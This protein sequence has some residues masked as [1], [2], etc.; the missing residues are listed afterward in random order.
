MSSDIVTNISGI[1]HCYASGPEN[2]QAC[3]RSLI[4]SILGLF[5]LPVVVFKLVQLH[6]SHA[7]DPY[8]LVVFYLAMAEV[9]VL[10]LHWLKYTGAIT[11]FVA[12]FCHVLQFLLIS[13][14]Y[15]RLA[16]GSGSAMRG[17]SLIQLSNYFVGVMVVYFF[18]VFLAAV[19][20][21]TDDDA[22][23]RSPVWLLFSTSKFCLALILLGAGY[24]MSKKI[25]GA[26][27]ES[28][29]QRISLMYLW[30]MIF[31][32]T[33]A[34]LV[35]FAID[36]AFKFHDSD[37]HCDYLFGLPDTSSYT[38][39]YVTIRI[40]TH[41]L[42]I[43]MMLWCLKPSGRRILPPRRRQIQVMSTS[44]SSR[45]LEDSF[46][47]DGA[48]D[49]GPLPELSGSADKHQRYHDDQEPTLDATW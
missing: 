16:A 25:M 48:D 42:P 1:Q 4:L 3:T 9:V 13:A 12:I 35:N 6:R 26:S 30:A 2:A 18:I 11:H 40:L 45:L 23:C 22:E 41:M 29:L 10:I 17:K 7:F 46:D 14:F 5:T 49:S 20:T 31:A 15:S 24:F 38:A 39:I 43:W 36:L 27:A 37:T 34:A 44:D 19:F 21:I 28:Q 47:F 32:F 8:R 33:V